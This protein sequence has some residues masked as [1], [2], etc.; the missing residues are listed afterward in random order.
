[1]PRTAAQGYV[2]TGALEI[3][4]EQAAATR[5]QGAD[6]RGK[7]Q[8]GALPGSFFRRFPKTERGTLGGFPTR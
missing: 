5:P 6:L 2:P 4:C 1:V 3:P 7:L 8:E